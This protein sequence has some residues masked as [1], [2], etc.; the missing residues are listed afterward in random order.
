MNQK[1]E[2][3]MSNLFPTR[4][5]F[6]DFGGR[7]FDDFFNQSLSNV[8]SFNT[9]IK[10]LEKEYV[11]EADL[12]GM[13]KDNIRLN[14]QDNVLSIEAK[15]DASKDERDDEGNYIRRERMSRSYSRQFVLKDVDEEGIKATFENGVLTVTLPKRQTKKSESGNIPID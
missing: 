1:G 2:G 12:P 5:D 10:E 15:T 3:K 11:L 4:R 14:Y 13:T 6:M 9:D 8:S 7:L